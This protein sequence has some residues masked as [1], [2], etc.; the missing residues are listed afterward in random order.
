MEAV[1]HSVVADDTSL[2]GA[3]RNNVTKRLRRKTQVQQA[4]TVSVSSSYS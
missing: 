4:K 1:K 2:S 3:P